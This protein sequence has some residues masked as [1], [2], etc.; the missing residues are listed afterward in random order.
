MMTSQN[1]PAE[2]MRFFQLF[3]ATYLKKALSEKKIGSL[4]HK[5]ILFSAGSCKIGP[6]DKQSQ[7][8]DFVKLQTSLFSLSV[9]LAI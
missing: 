9:V 5:A 6:S 4:V 7:E 8:W 3:R 2:I 1:E